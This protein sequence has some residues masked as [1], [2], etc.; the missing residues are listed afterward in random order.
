MHWAR[1]HM[2]QFFAILALIYMFLPVMIVLVFSF[3]QPNGRFNYTWNKFSLDAWPGVFQDP[4]ILHS[5][6]LSLKIGLVATAVS[7]LLGTLI[8]FAIGRHR[9]RGRAATN[10]LIFMPMATPEVVMGASLLSLFILTKQDGSLGVITIT[11][12]HI[13]F[14]I[15]FVVVTV[16]ARIA[17]LDPRLEQAAMDL[18]A[19]EQ[20][21]FWK[22]TFPLV[23]PG[24]VAGG[25]LAFSLSF[26]D[27]IIT[28]FT[29]GNTI[30][31]PMYVW[32]AAGKGIPPEANVVGSA[33]FIIAFII[34][35]IPELA[36]RKSKTA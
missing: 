7:T 8:A 1:N 21:T 14:C 29:S 9:F 32:G 17:G 26:D 11:I 31:F 15:S 34:V 13:M 30:T 16:K 27:F 20:T 25:L 5:V 2:I 23:L 28:N 22:V 33:M 12:A 35:L 4:E 3:N 6:T 18:Y 19:N 36:R 10:L 24:I